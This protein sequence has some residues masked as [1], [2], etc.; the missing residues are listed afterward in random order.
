MDRKISKDQALKVM[1]DNGIK[2]TPQR[3][4][5]FNYLIETDLHP[6]VDEI[7]RAL[8]KDFPNISIATIYNNLEV[9]K[10]VGLIQDQ[11]FDGG[12]RRFE[13]N[14]LKHHHVICKKCGIIKDFYD[15]SLGNIEPYVE[16]RMHYK[17]Y[18]YNVTMYG[19]CQECQKGINETIKIVQK[20]ILTAYFK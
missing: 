1:K 4:A 6:T 20:S 8:N 3:S 18:T 15:N 5:I 9:L 14:T 17:T 16:Q 11:T 12:F 7:Y 2:I 10:N 19:I 13:Y